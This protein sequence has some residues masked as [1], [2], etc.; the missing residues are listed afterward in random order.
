MKLNFT[1]V[2]LISLFVYLF[3]FFVVYF[4]NL[5]NLI[6]QSEDLITTSAVPF[7]ILKQGNLN[8][9]EY[10]DLFV[11]NYPNPDDK[12][13]LTYYLR[14][15]EGHYYSAFPM[16][17]SFLVTPI[18]VVPVLLNL[19]VTINL[20]SIMSRVGGALLAA[21]AV[22]FFYLF[23]KSYF[24]K[25]SV[26][27]AKLS[28]KNIA[29]L[30]FIYAF[31]TNMFSLNS[32]G[33][34]QHTTSNLLIS[35]ALYFLVKNK[36]GFTGFI[37]GLATIA[38]PTNLLSLAVF[39]FFIFIKNKFKLKII[40]RYSVFAL[41]PIIFEVS[42]MF[43]IYGSLLNTGYGS[44]INTWT[45]SLVEGFLGMWFSPSKG[46]LI[47]SPVFIFSLYG[48]YLSI[49]NF[50]L[51]DL[52]FLSSKI[53]IAHTLILSLW[54]HWYGGYSWGYRMASDIIP[55]LIILL[56][57]FVTSKYMHSKKM[58]LLF[59]FTVVWSVFIQLLG[60][61]VFDGTWHLLYDK[62]SKNTDWLWSIKDN[63]IFFSVKRIFYKIGVTNSNP[64]KILK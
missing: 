30:V 64:I 61:I 5:N 16:L 43:L 18:Y 26:Y 37:L 46:I 17:T 11:S 29:L 6:L 19:P 35:L 54:H 4:F 33:L 8:L 28:N 2:F 34:W 45:G 44:Q 63:Q 24:T 40:V 23:L 53:V 60:I 59:Y 55:F 14:T 3:S 10:H 47:I 56:I 7:S 32:Q 51:F 9:D 39:A 13:A 15:T 31:A 48:M 20:I 25:K 27:F 22:A 42:L 36:I 57:P 58:S 62:G 38:R 21:L 1:K 12:L 41:I 52:D 50:K 49:K